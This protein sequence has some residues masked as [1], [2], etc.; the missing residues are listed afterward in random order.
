M[1]RINFFKVFFIVTVVVLYSSPVT[2]AC[3]VSISPIS[4]SFDSSGGNGSFEG[5][6]S[7]SNCTWYATSNDS[8]VVIT[9]GVGGYHY[10][11]DTVEYTVAPNPSAIQREGAIVVG[12]EIHTITQSGI[13]CS[14]ELSPTSK[15]FEASGDS[16][17][18]NVLAPSGC[19]WTAVSNDTW[20]TIY[21]GSSGSGNGAVYYTVE[22]KLTIGSRQGTLTIAGETFTISQSG[23]P[24]SEIYSINVTSIDENEYLPIL[25][26]SGTLY[27]NCQPLADAWIGGDDPIYRQ[28]KV[29]FVQTDSQGNFTRTWDITSVKPAIYQLMLYV[30]PAEK[31]ISLPVVGSSRS[32]KFYTAGSINFDIGVLE[33]PGAFF[34]PRTLSCSVVSDGCRVEA[35]V[36]D[37]IKEDLKGLKNFMLDWNS[38]FWYDIAKNPYNT[39]VGAG[40]ATCLL[41]EPISKL[42][43]CPASVTFVSVSAAKSL[44]RSFIQ[45][46][47]NNSNLSEDDKQKAHQYLDILSTTYSIFVLDPGEGVLSALDVGSIGWES[48]EVL[49]YVELEENSPLSGIF[50]VAERTDG[51]IV[52]IAI[53][54]SKPKAMPWLMLLLDE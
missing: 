2:Y 13:P 30:G 8:W 16:A 42:S 12:S 53:S 4:A 40:V 35:P 28:C 38:N 54:N 10:D 23:I 3:T 46:R 34:N 36:L 52:A 31:Q 17:S 5:D 18:L 19:A 37:Q 1:R 15:S 20:I 9:S 24:C 21:Y 22:A 49:S 33:T 25:T 39:V 14:Y 45:T 41:P 44:I 6:A 26:I 47:I 11:D 29:N 50:I 7:T 32:D 48:T 43:I 27:Y 51:T